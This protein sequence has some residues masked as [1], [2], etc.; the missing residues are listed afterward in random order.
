MFD[1][2]IEGQDNGIQHS[3]WCRSTEN[4]NLYKSHTLAFCGSSPFSRYSRFKIRDLQN[5]GQCH[6]TYNIR[7]GFNQ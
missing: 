3:Q 2:E 6:C 4:I 7:S 1:L 5:V